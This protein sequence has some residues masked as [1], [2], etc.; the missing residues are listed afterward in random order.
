MRIV[1]KPSDDAPEY[2]YYYSKKD[3]TK[4]FIV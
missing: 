1:V 3:E 4:M 2:M